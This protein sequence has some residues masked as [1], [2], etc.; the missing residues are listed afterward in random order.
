VTAANTAPTAISQN[1]TGPFNN[2]LLLTLT[3]DDP[4]TP[5]S[6]LVYTVVTQPQHG[7]LSISGA[8]ITYKP[9]DRFYGD[10]SFRFTVT[11]RGNPDNCGAPGPSCAPP[12]TSSPGT[13]SIAIPRPPAAV[14]LAPQANPQTVST[15]QNT[16]K[17]ILLTGSD[18]ETAA[19]NLTFTVISNPSHGTLSGIPPNVTYTPA[20]NYFGPDSF[21]FKVTDRGSPDGCSGDEV[22][23][24]GVRDSAPVTV[25]ISVHASNTVP[26]ANAQSVTT[27]ENTAKDISLAGSDTET[28]AANLTYTVTIPP[29]HGSLTGTAPN[30]TYTPAPG[31]FGADAFQ[32]TVTDRGNPDNCGAV[33]VS[34]AAMATSPAATVA[35]TVVPVNTAPT[36]TAQSVSTDENVAKAITLAGTDTE[37][38]PANLSVNVTVNPAHGTLT[39]T[40]P[41]LTY[42]PNANYIGSDSFQFTVTDRGKPDNCGTAGSTC[43]AAFT[44]PAATV[45]ITVLAVNTPPTANPQSIGTNEG[46]AIPVIL[47]GS[48]AETSAANLTFTVTT[49]PAHGVLTGT[50]PNLAYAPAPGYYG[51]DS[52]QFKVRDQGNP[53]SCGAPGNF[54]AAALDSIIATVTIAIV[55]VNTAPAATAQSVNANE[56]T[57]TP[58]TL[59]GTDA[60]TT[61]ANLTF[62]IAVNPTHGTLSGSAPNLTYTPNANYTGLDSFQFTV[63]DRGKPDNCGAPNVGCSAAL[64]SSAATVSITVVAVNAAPT[65]NAQSVSTN[66]GAALPITLTGSDPETAAANLTYTVSTP[67]AHGSL[68]GIAPNLTYTPA[69]GYFGPDSFQFTVTDRGKP[70]NCGTPNPPACLATATSPAATVAITVVP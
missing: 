16:P 42:T 64:T 66:E 28:A 13:I 29:A 1:L 44:S 62:T 31:Y 35:I 38:S 68:T 11:D 17:P 32:F 43:S 22:F 51:V 67:P 70:D 23:C 15:N 6:A 60:E 39:G 40:A 46:V 54:C 4:E 59:A 36:A 47:A 30:L 2:L 69:A 52:F 53:D 34:C 63:T 65:A 5:G 19:A 18:A 41:N 14:N 33:G 48:D 58:I 8:K 20:S 10:D 7:A 24:A 9:D 27:S 45:S 50:A 37:T 56:N 26:T 12:L 61:A 21:Q 57:A 3:G 49:S 55:P 25:S